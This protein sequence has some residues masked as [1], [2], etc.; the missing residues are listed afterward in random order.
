MIESS[1]EDR[2]SLR[3]GGSFDKRKT[4]LNLIIDLEVSLDNNFDVNFLFCPDDGFREGFLGGFPRAG[5][6]SS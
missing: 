4:H 5:S 1:L 2:C 6:P 3:D